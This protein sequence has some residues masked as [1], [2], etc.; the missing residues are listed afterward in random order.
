M[1][2]KREDLEIKRIFQRWDDYR[3]QWSP[4]SCAGIK[5]VHMTMDT[6]WLPQMFLYHRQVEARLFQR[7]S[8][9]QHEWRNAHAIT[10][11]DCTG[12]F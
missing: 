1:S 5:S 12:V 2:F 10:R 3:I 6:V 9:L 4:E 8:I 7:K 11:L